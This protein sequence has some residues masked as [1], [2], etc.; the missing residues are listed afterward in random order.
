MSSD[1]F[2]LS[3]KIALVT[4]AGR[5][6]G[7]AMAEGLGAAGATVVLNDRIGDRLEGAER[8]LRDKGLKVHASLFDV[9]DGAAVKRA[10]AD[11]EARIGPIHI[12]INNAGVQDRQPTQSF[13]EAD[14]QRVL[15]TNLT[16]PLL[17]AQA[18]APGMIER[19]AG[20]IVN[21]GSIIGLLGRANSAPYAVAKGGLKMLTKVMAVEWAAHGIQVN[22][23]APGYFATEMTRPFQED[24]VIDPYIRGHTPAARWGQPSDL[25]GTVVYLSS[26]ASAFVTGQVIYVDGGYSSTT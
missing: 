17:V 4:G 13:P 1:L 12:L 9:S 11:I 7:L 18:V 16:G 14:W 21:I 20:K 3:G 23:L 24:P 25:I 19:G 6:L 5:G 8:Q 10:V 22:T 26:K 2:D 15:D